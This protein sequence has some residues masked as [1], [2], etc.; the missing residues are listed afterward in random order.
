[1]T[2]MGEGHGL[3]MIAARLLRDLILGRPK[4]DPAVFGFNR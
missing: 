1:M 3:A 2:R 4:E